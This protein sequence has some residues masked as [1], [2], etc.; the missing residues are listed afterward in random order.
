MLLALNLGG[1][2]EQLKSQLSFVHPEPLGMLA[3]DERGPGKGTKKKTLRLYVYPDI[4]DHTVYL[5]LLGDKSSQPNDIA[6][7]KTFV[8]ELQNKHNNR[9]RSDSN[10]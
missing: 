8:L 2:V 6:L 5:M 9:L 4:I 1:K 10:K 3:L 7:C